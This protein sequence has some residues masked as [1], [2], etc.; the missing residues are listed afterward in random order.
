MRKVGVLLLVLVHGLQWMRDGQRKDKII[1]RG[2][3]DRFI[4]GL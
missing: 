2:D 3:Y 4:S 1:F